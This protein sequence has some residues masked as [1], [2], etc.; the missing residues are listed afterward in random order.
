MSLSLSVQDTLH[1]L[2]RLTRYWQSLCIDLCRQCLQ[3]RV[4]DGFCVDELFGLGLPS[5]SGL[6]LVAVKGQVVVV[7]GDLTLSLS[8]LGREAHTRRQHGCYLT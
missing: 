2:E 7:S 4:M 6:E 1:R 3:L 8:S 5:L